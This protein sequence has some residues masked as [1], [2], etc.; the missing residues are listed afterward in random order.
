MKNLFALFF[1]LTLFVSCNG[2]ESKKVAVFED[3]EDSIGY[4]EENES[5]DLDNNVVAIPFS[6]VDGVKVV[7]VTIN[8]AIGVN[9]IIDTGCSGAMISLSEARY[10]VEKGALTIDDVVG[11]G[12]SMVADGRIVANMMV[13][14]KV[15]SINS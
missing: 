7:E 10:L 11:E 13:R 1:L 8:D 3:Y 14:L 12:Q 4:E 2:N 5:G 6:V 15:G 9:M